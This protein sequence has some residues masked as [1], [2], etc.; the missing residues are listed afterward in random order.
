MTIKEFLARLS[1]VVDKT[2]GYVARCPA[3]GALSLLIGEGDNRILLRC[4]LGCSKKSILSA[5]NLNEKDLFFDSVPG[6]KP[7]SAT[8]PTGKRKSEPR[9]QT[10]EN[11]SE[12]FSGEITYLWRRHLPAGMPV[13]V[14]AREGTGK[15]LTCL[16]MAHEI[17]N[18][19]DGYIVWL[20]TEGFVLDTIAKAKNIGLGKRFLVAEKEDGDFRFDFRHR[21]DFKKFE[22]VLQQI[23]GRLLCVFIDSIRGM[24]G[25]DDNDSK[26]GAIMHKLNSLVCD[27]YGATLVY[28]DHWRKSKASNIL[29]KAVGSTA[30]TAA[31]RVVL[32][33]VPVSTYVRQIK[34]AKNN[35]NVN[36]PV[37]RSTLIGGNIQFSSDATT[38]EETKTRQAEQWLVSLFSKRQKILASE[39]YKLGE[40]EGFH[41]STL[42]RL[43]SVLAIP[44]TKCEGRYYW[45]SPFGIESVH[46]SNTCSK[47]PVKTETCGV[48]QE[49]FKG[50]GVPGV[51]GV[52]G[53][54]G[55]QGVHPKKTLNTC[56]NSCVN[57]SLQENLSN[58]PIEN[59]PEW[60]KRDFEAAKTLSDEM[61][62]P[63]ETDTLFDINDFKIMKKDKR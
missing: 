56:V 63:H 18:T 55:V 8:T 57:A 30:K 17:L 39:V 47:N 31:V 46:T 54:P 58:I 32:S 40:S 41:E 16:A 13:I 15:T 24:S 45:I 60:I 62:I 21:G 28:V 25:S 27:K 5:M 23:P 2:G 34:I 20:A 12:K 48:V 19:H 3:C 6:S 49:V 42:R 10:L 43:K 59:E 50:G 29:D 36:T 61:A 11:L 53:V 35:L 7:Q 1:D 33:I 44:H 38:E 9:L 4:D 22:Q 26:V 52:P 51:Q 14:N 37:L